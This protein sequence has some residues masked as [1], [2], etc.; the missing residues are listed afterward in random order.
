MPWLWCKPAAIAPTP[1]PARELPYA[2]GVAL[3][4]KKKKEAHPGVREREWGQL[5]GKT[6]GTW[7]VLL[8]DPSFSNSSCPTS[9]PQ[10]GRGPHQPRPRR[11]AGVWLG[12]AVGPCPCP[13]GPSTGEA[14][15]AWTCAHSGCWGGAL[16][17]EGAL[18][19]DSSCLAAPSLFF[20]VFLSFIGPHPQHMEAPRLGV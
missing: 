7:P 4:R 8:L 1:P 10:R 11:A 19:S 2:V 14:Q 6:A 3:K 9:P 15:E 16:G 5:L 12:L 17:G 18:R 13:P 20:F